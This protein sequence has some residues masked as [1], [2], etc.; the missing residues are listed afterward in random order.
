MGAAPDPCAARP[1]CDGANDGDGRTEGCSRMT[2][3]EIPHRNIALVLAAALLFVL[4]T[5]IAR[6]EVCVV[7]D[8]TGTPLNVR[9]SARRSSAR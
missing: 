2:V 5:G 6:A 9:A 1:Q 8:P 4:F 7:A 3:S